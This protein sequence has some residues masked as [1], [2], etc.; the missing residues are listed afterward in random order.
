MPFFSELDISLPESA[1]ASPAGNQRVCAFQNR[2][3]LPETEVEG[4]ARQ[5]GDVRV[6]TSRVTV[7]GYSWVP[8]FPSRHSTYPVCSTGHSRDQGL[9]ISQ[10]FLGTAIS[11]TALPG[12]HSVYLKKIFFS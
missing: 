11:P 1:E 6:D 9:F 7:W 3:L 4:Q 2:A 5:Q 10:S 12:A 8:K